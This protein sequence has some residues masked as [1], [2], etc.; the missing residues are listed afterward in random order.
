MKKGRNITRR[1]DV[2][3]VITKMK[4]YW[5]T[6][7][8]KSGMAPNYK[9]Q[10]F[11]SPPAETPPSNVDR[12]EFLK[13]MGASAALASMAVSCRRPVEKIV[14]YLNMPEEITPGVAEWY[15]S[16]CGECPAAC[17]T[18]VKTREG[19]PI[20]LEGNPDHPLS[21]WGLCARGQAS[22]L[23]LYDPARLK[24]PVQV[25]RTEGTHKEIPWL[26]ADEA[27]VRYLKELKG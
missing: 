1:S 19:R 13:I 8:E 4:K 17:G 9:G 26:E 2:R 18:L 23:N 5:K 11:L 27:M 24:G 10:E 15:A 25:S 6:L 12:R 16:T 3:R 7:E 22:L 14:P 21:Q 20:K